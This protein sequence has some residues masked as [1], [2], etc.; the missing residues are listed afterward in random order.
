[1]SSES[2]ALTLHG[3]IDVK[4]WVETDN[5]TELAA[6]I[7]I[8]D[9]EFQGIIELEAP[10]NLSTNITKLKVNSLKVNT[11]TFGKISAFQLKLELNVGLAVA[12]PVLAKKIDSIQLPT[13]LTSHVK[14]SDLII[15][16]YDGF[17]GVGATPTFVPPPL[18]PAP[19]NAY[20]GYKV[21]VENK[22]GFVLRFHLKNTHTAEQS[23]VTDKYPI[24]KTKCLD[25][26][27]ALPDVQEGEIIKTIVSATAG[28]T[29]PTEHYTIYQADPK[30]TTTFTCRGTTLNFHCNDEDLD[31]DT[32]VGLADLI[33]LFIQ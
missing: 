22:A 6:D 15:K 25:I 11:C 16:Y 12:A 13:N 18:P 28:D 33:A 10:F 30:V 2:P 7:A 31:E 9:F 23:D 21:C 3:G 5:G 4:F 1:M 14:F 24:D 27:E 8:T 29:N 32:V 20:P 26:K 19:E 17:L